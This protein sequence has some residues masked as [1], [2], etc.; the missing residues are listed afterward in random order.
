MLIIGK[1]SKVYSLI[2]DKISDHISCSHKDDIEMLIKKNSIKK[3]LVLSNSPRLDENIKLIKL[4]YLSNVEICYISTSAAKYS[5][6][7]IYAYPRNKRV[8]EQVIYQYF[9]RFLILRC[10]LIEGLHDH[11]KIHGRVPVTAL[12]D[13]CQNINKFIQEDLYGTLDLFK[14]T[15]ISSTALNLFFFKCYGFINNLPLFI[16]RPCDYILRLFK[17]HNYGYLYRQG[18]EEL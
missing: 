14:F 8:A 16:S 13:I 3:V 1:N 17:Y 7:Q 10:G 6:C 18:N 2:K 9:K 15:N 11:S 4:L 5:S 12:N